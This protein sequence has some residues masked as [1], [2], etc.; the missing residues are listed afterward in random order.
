MYVKYLLSWKC[1][2]DL[3]RNGPIDY[4]VKRKYSATK[5]MLNDKVFMCGK[6][7]GVG[8]LD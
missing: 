1:K 6:Y 7:C 2:I 3:F 4:F 5:I 8:K